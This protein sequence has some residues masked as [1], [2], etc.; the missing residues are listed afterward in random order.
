[1]TILEAIKILEHFQKWHTGSDIEMIQPKVLTKAIDLI[2]KE[3]KKCTKV[4]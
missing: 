2:L 1:M 4:Q 3:V